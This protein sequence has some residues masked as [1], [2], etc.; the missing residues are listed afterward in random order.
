MGKPAKFVDPNGKHIRVYT[1]LLNS[2]A[3]RVLGYAAKAL[4]VDLR[5]KVNGSN[6][7]NI[8]AV[9]SVLKH[10]GWTS[11]GTLSR[12]LYELRTMGFL[13]QTR[14][15][16]VEFGSRVCSLYRFTDL[17]SFDQPKLG[18]TAC[19]PSHDYLR[20]KT[21]AEAEQALRAGVQELREKAVA[22]KARA[23]IAGKTTL[24]IL[25]RTATETVAI[26][27][28]HRYENSSREMANATKSVAV[29]L[30]R[31]TPESLTGRG[32]QGNRVGRND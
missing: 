30:P 12:A 6:N 2:P 27:P 18:I 25:K 11:P 22:R 31:K 5:E 17:P 15:G 4:F 14:G 16:G 8:E 26:D 13:E 29:K 7:G 9:M 32:F 19:R 24:R 10:K 20:F 28:F 3:Y 1:S 21:L 23:G